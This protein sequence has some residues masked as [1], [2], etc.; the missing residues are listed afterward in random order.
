MSYLKVKL[1]PFTTPNFVLTE[2]KPGLRQDGFEP[3][4]GVPI[5]DLDDIT[6]EE[7]IQEF[8]ENLREKVRQRR[9]TNTPQACL[10]RIERRARSGIGKAGL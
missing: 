2:S 3:R 1:Q 8:G 7:L 6:I 4:P 5:E 10:E 9:I